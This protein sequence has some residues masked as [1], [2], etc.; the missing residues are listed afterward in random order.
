MHRRSVPPAPPLRPRKKPAAAAARDL[1]PPNLCSLGSAPA[2][3]AMAPASPMTSFQPPLAVAI[4]GLF[5]T[6]DRP[7]VDGLD[8]SIRVGEFYTLLG[9]NGAGKTTTLRM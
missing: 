3:A 9:P 2:F 4:R 7:A 6:F 1:R 8:L 5:K